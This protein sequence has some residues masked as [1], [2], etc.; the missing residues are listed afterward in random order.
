MVC[1]ITQGDHSKIYTNQTQYVE[2]LNKERS[3]QWL[4]WDVPTARHVD[5][6]HGKTNGI[7]KLSTVFIT[8]LQNHNNKSY[9][10]RVTAVNKAS[11]FLSKLYS[12]TPV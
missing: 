10:S 5:S 3:H 6:I 2:Q 11:L 9:I 12:L 8:S 1:P 4:A 7:A